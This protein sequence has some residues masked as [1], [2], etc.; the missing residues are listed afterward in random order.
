M[1]ASRPEASKSAVLAPE[2]EAGTTDSQVVTTM[3][4]A[5]SIDNRNTIDEGNTKIDGGDGKTR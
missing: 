5:R 3:N 1:P 4:E 2:S